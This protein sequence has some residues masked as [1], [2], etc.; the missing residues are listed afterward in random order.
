MN[1]LFKIINNSINNKKTNKSNQGK[2]SK[3]FMIIISI[4]IIIILAGD[5][6][7]IVY[8]VFIKP[9]HIKYL[10]YP[11][12]VIYLYPNGY[13]Y[14]SVG[15]SS[16]NDIRIP[17]ITFYE[18]IYGS[19]NTSGSIYV[20]IMSFSQFNSWASHGE[21]ISYLLHSLWFSNSNKSTI[22][23]NAN[24]NVD[25]VIVFYNPSKNSSA[26]VNI[27]SDGIYVKYLGLP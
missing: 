15:P 8:F 20:A 25:Y 16:Y 10:V 13:S 3:G 12:N 21:N 9:Y 27:N 7:G 2:N 14:V 17:F 19:Y 22:N 23:F 26:S 18:H 4:L 1:K 6:Y 11:N 5:I 24:P